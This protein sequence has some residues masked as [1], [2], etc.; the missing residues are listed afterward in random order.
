LVIVLYTLVDGQGARLS[1]HAFSYTGW[2]L[3]LTALVLLWVL[4]KGM[5]PSLFY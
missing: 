2:L 1:G 3:F 5:G 4:M